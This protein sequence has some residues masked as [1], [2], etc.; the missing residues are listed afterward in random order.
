MVFRRIYWVVEDLN[1]TNS[2][3]RG[4][5]TSVADLTDRL[6]AELKTSDHIRLSLMRLD[7]DHGTLG[8]WNSPDFKSLIDDLNEFIATGEF[9]YDEC[10]GLAQSLSEKFMVPA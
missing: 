8:S 9:T 10:H 2:S 3:V 4:V 7:K 6:I 1:S 5:F